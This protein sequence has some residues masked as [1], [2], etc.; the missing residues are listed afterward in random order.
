MNRTVEKCGL[1]VTDNYRTNMD[2][3]WPYVK[4]LPWTS[5]SFQNAIP[6]PAARSAPVTTA[7]ARVA[8]QNEHT[9]FVI[10]QEKSDVDNLCLNSEKK[11]R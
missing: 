11:Q 6:I 3:Y 7:P 2:I 10:L 8:L 9:H 1:I 5:F 4:K